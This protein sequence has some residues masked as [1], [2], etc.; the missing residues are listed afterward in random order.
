MVSWMKIAVTGGSGLIGR[1]LVTRLESAGHRVQLLGRSPRRGTLRSAEFAIWDPEKTAPVAALEGSQAVVHLAGE[2]VAQRWSREAKRRIRSSRV[3]GTARL[4]EGISKCTDPPKVLVCASAVGFYGDRGLD[5]LD[6]ASGPGTGF[7]P[8]V[9][10]AWEAASKG[11]ETLGVR[12]VP[13]RIG[14]V[15]AADGGA[16]DKMLPV[17]RLGLGGKLGDGAQYMS[18]IH[19]DDL[20]SMFLWALEDRN[21]SGPVN[22]VSPNPVTNAE[23]TRELGRA[24][25]RPAIL[26]VPRLAVDLLYGEM[27]EILFHSQRAKPAAALK[28][29]F[30]FRHPEIYGALRDVVS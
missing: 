6:E 19:I 11:V 15:L 1:L 22:G 12:R 29:G 24:L 23:F 2:P 14:L 4:V 28:G 8:E 7:L 21:V 16:L 18:W 13:I 26:P 25:G 9:C 3:E 20:V 27:A 30:E 10:V 5:E 17:F